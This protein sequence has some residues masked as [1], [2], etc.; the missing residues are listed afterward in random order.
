[1]LIVGGLWAVVL[2]TGAVVLLPRPRSSITR[3]GL[4]WM[5][6]LAGM[7]AGIVVV[8]L[9][10]SHPWASGYHLAYLLDSC[11]LGW[12][13]TALAVVAGAVIALGR[14][15]RRERTRE[16]TATLE[17]ALGATGIFAIGALWAVEPVWACCPTGVAFVPAETSARNAA[18]VLWD[19]ALL[20]AAASGALSFV[21]VARAIATRH[22]RPALTLL[23]PIAW[24]AGSAAKDVL[25]SELALRVASVTPI[26]PVAPLATAVA[27]AGRIA[28]S[29]DLA[30]GACI[31]LVL[32][33]LTLTSLSARPRGRAARLGLGAIVPVI[34][35]MLALASPGWA[36]PLV[37]THQQ[38]P[39]PVWLEVDDFEPMVI[40]DEGRLAQ[41]SFAT[42]HVV[43]A[44]AH[45]DGTLHV[46]SPD[47][48]APVR[49]SERARAP[50]GGSHLEVL[51]FA[52]A[53]LADLRRVA[54]QVEGFSTIRVIALR[55]PLGQLPARVRSRW[56]FLEQVARSARVLAEGRIGPLTGGRNQLTLVYEPIPCE[57]TL[58]DGR[59]VFAEARDDLPL[60]ELLDLRTCTPLEI[61]SEAA[62]SARSEIL[63]RDRA[64]WPWFAQLARLSIGSALGLAVGLFA[65]GAVITRAMRRRAALDRRAISW[66]REALTMAAIVPFWVPS[67]HADRVCLRHDLQGYRSTARPVIEARTAS[68]AVALRELWRAVRALLRHAVITGA[69]VLAPIAALA[70]TMILLSTL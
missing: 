27:D 36:P 50:F 57:V 2:A 59:L 31:A 52:G 69:L 9:T 37:V 65:C 56:G 46:F 12:R 19:R 32:V 43:L 6:A 1:M 64:G 67:A 45:R 41:F 20:G 18:E 4:S 54:A 10:T 3:A 21:V 63:R 47:R 29:I 7:G 40:G 51:F 44:I 5:I 66:W 25:G 61:A 23:P 60:E 48:R 26:A 39:D 22:I 17:L 30:I 8:L 11:F 38:A 13:A 42:P 35:A 68:R 34:V 49:P 33:T 53:T 58:R 55:S 15:L 14:A 62:T 28:D 70:L 16:G 24:L